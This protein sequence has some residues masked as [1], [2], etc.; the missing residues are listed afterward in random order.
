MHANAPGAPWTLKSAVAHLEALLSSPGFQVRTAAPSHAAVLAQTASEH[1]D[2]CGNLV[3][4]LHTAVI[5]REHSVKRTC[6]RDSDFRR[7]PF[8]EVVD[9]L[10]ESL[11]HQTGGFMQ[12]GTTERSTKLPAS[13]GCTGLA[14]SACLAVR[15]PV[16]RGRSATWSS[17]S[18]RD[19]TCCG[20][21]ALPAR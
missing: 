21:R 11:E 14:V 2:A 19:S 8:L 1:R 12:T 5:M 3:H 20:P 7:F 6:T 17:A 9:P 13:L 18:E 4:D 10:S 15:A 16:S